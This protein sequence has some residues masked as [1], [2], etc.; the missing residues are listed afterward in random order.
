MSENIEDHIKTEYIDLHV[1]FKLKKDM[2]L[3]EEICND[4]KGL[5]IHI[6]DARYGLTVNGKSLGGSGFPFNK[7]SIVWCSSCYNGVR[8]R[9]KHCNDL[10]DKRW[11]ECQC[12][13]SKEERGVA[14]WQIEKA[15][16][17]KAN[18]ISYSESLNKYKMIFVDDWNKYIDTDSLAEEIEYWL[19]DNMKDDT[20]EDIIEQIL[21]IKIYGTST[22]SASFDAESILEN[23]TDDLHDEAYSNARH[24]I[25]ELQE[26]LDV[27]AEKIKD[28]TG[29]YNANSEGIVLTRDDIERFGL[30]RLS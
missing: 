22:C 2:K 4:C 3:N 30:S 26:A 5:G 10:V 12:E 9:C 27:A 17:E 21:N 18:K 16:W 25:G 6:Y 7:E 23:A 1:D 29:T 15:N 13:R 11:V 8:K 19:D 20:E 24:I 14:S 28:D